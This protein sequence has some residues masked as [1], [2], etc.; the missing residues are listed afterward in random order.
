M[1]ERVSRAVTRQS[2][3]QYVSSKLSKTEGACPAVRDSIQNAHN[4]QIMTNKDV[5]KHSEKVFQ[6]QQ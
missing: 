2:K 5:Y 6:Q 4:I 1:S 3:L